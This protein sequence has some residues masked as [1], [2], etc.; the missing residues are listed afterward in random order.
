MYSRIKMLFDQYKTIAKN[1]FYLMIVNGIMLLLPFIAMPYIIRVCGVE[2]F[3]RIVFAQ[4]VIVYF[5]ILINFGLNTF[6]IREVAQNSSSVEKISR[7]AG[8]YISLRLILG[9]A[10]FIILSVITS[11]IPFLQQFT[12]LLFYCFIYTLA[13]NLTMSVF[14]QGM[15]KMHNIALFQ[16]VFIVFY[17]VSLMS[18]VRNEDDYELVVLLQA[19]GM[20]IFALLSIVWLRI[21]YKITLQ[22]PSIKNIWSMVKGSVPFTISLI[23]GIINENI[24]KIFCGISLGMHD[25]A[26]LDVAQKI[27]TAALLP[28]NIVD[29]AIY[30]HN[31]KK[32]DRAFAS[33]QFYCFTGLGIVC[34]LLLLAGTP[35]AVRFFGQGKLSD[36]VLIIYLLS[37][38]VPIESLAYYGGAPTLVAFGYT[39]TYTLSFLYGVLAVIVIYPI[40]YFT[41]NITLKTVVLVMISSSALVAFYR[42]YYCRKFK[43]LFNR[44]K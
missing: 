16:T 33:K 19:T 11:C 14:F 24:A 34:T 23:V 1:S 43:L 29:Q 17:I 30:P 4:S 25:L 10:G 38:K 32:Q 13:E 7:I 31:A 40:L 28:V 37:I 5:Y 36:A 20:L 42:L 15:E 26:V 21:K 22:T 3:G 8:T 2:N 9:I 44:N 12:V 27:I 6:T 18:F 41:G 35:F 39:K